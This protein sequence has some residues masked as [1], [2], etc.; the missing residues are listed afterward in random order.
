VSRVQNSAAVKLFIV[1]FIVGAGI[2]FALRE[3]G[4]KP[5]GAAPPLD[6]S[7]GM[8]QSARQ[9]F[10]DGDFTIIRD[11]RVLPSPVLEAFSEQNGSKLVIAN[12]GK[13]FTV[14]DVIY[15]STLPQ[16]RLIFAG[17]SG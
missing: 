2:I 5:L 14:G 3:R 4:R 1:V 7:S 15:D 9:Q 8:S 12:P 17:V 11:A 13:A 6:F 16:K 10:F